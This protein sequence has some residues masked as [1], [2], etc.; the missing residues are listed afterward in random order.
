VPECL[1][2][3]A[4]VRYPAESFCISRRVLIFVCLDRDELGRLEQDITFAQEK[5]RNAL[6]AHTPSRASQTPEYA[7]LATR[8]DPLLAH[9]NL[10]LITSRLLSLQV[11]PPLSACCL[12]HARVRASIFLFMPVFVS[13]CAGG[14]C[15]QQNVHS[16]RF[17]RPCAARLRHQHP[18]VTRMRCGIIRAALWVAYFGFLLRVRGSRGIKYKGYRCICCQ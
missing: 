10:H 11:S 14:V 7:L 18:C 4:Q 6:T 15:A 9:I 3:V 12:A 2:E 8:L 16:L 5:F 17:L 13:M 1:R